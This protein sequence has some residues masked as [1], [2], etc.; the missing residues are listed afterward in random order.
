MAFVSGLSLRL[1]LQ[2]ASDKDT[3]WLNFTKPTFRNTW[4]WVYNKLDRHI[5]WKVFICVKL[6]LHFLQ[7]IKKKNLLKLF[8]ELVRLQISRQISSFIIIIIFSS[9]F[10]IELQENSSPDLL[11]VVIFWYQ[12]LVFRFRSKAGSQFL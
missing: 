3:S 11:V 4:W 8:V 2:W 6:R 5:F 1:G 12:V 10:V 7:F 9:R